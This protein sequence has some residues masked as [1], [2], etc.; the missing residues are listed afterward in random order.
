MTGLFLPLCRHYCPHAYL[1]LGWKVGPIGPEQ[2]Y[3]AY[4]IT[5]M[6]S[7][8][9]EY[10]LPGSSVVF[11]A[12]LR[13]SERALGDV[14]SILTRVPGSQLLLWTGFGEAPVR[15]ELHER[16]L[17]KMHVLGVGER[18]GFDIAVTHGM[19]GCAA[20][21][22]IDCTYAA[23]RRVAPR[24]APRAISAPSAVSRSFVWSRWSRYICCGQLCCGAPVA[25]PFGR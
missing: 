6:A 7:I 21:D 8:V 3:T 10:G 11:A 2:T 12:S 1:S 9:A 20:S 23:A 13:M 24:A 19:L 16:A 4:D 14:A 25:A 5:E 18:V 15:S 17:D 22:A